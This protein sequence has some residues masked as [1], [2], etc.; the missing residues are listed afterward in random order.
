[1]RGKRWPLRQPLELCWSR[2]RCLSYCGALAVVL[3][4]AIILRNWNHFWCCNNCFFLLGVS[5]YSMFLALLEFSLVDM[6]CVIVV[7]LLNF[8]LCG[9]LLLLLLCIYSGFQFA[10]LLYWLKLLLIWQ[11]SVLRCCCWFFVA[12]L[13]AT[14]FPISFSSPLRPFLSFML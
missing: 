10:S 7:V 8:S 4:V 9:M 2:G 11:F 12:Y 3:C 13:L 6:L 14:F 5:A 1:M